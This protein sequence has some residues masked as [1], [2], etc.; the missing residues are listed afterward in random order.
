MADSNSSSNRD[1]SSLSEKFRS[2]N[3]APRAQERGIREP[4]VKCSLNNSEEK[5]VNTELQF[6]PAKPAGDQGAL[7]RALAKT[8][9]YLFS[10]HSFPGE[11]H[12]GQII[13]DMLADEKSEAVIRIRY[14]LEST[15]PIDDASVKDLEIKVFS[16]DE[17]F[18]R[19]VQLTEY[20]KFHIEVPRIFSYFV[21][22]KV[23]RY[24]QRKRNIFYNR[25][26]SRLQNESGMK[27]ITQT[28]SLIPLKEN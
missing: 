12:Y 9:E 10:T 22:P 8:K 5:A 26:C 13:K 28:S 6:T 19:L 1:L 23:L 25:V 18:E 17:G 24:H 11:A 14:L 4:A 16:F 15:I 27:S 20:Y 3:L 7:Q 2:E 21:G